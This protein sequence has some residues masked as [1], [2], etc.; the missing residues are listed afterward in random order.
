MLMHEKPCLIPILE[1]PQLGISSEHPDD[2][3]WCIFNKIVLQT[4]P[5]PPPPPPPPPPH[6]W[7]T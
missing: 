3:F 4:A 6:H 1:L 2:T 5:R 7:M